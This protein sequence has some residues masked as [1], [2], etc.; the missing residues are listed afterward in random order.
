MRRFRVTGLLA[1]TV[2]IVALVLGAPAGAVAQAKVEIHY[3]TYF[4]PAG[5]DANS[6]AQAEFIRKFHE[7]NPDIKVVMDFVPWQ[8]L[9]ELLHQSVAAGKGPD[10]VGVY[11]M[12]LLQHLEAGNLIPLD[13]YARELASE[14]GDFL[15]WEGTVWQGKKW[16]FFREILVEMLFVRR[17]LVT[18]A[19]APFPPR[20][21]KQVAQASA[22]ITKE[23]MWGIMI[24]LSKKQ[25]ANR[26]MAFFTYYLWGEEGN[27]V[28][29]NGRAAFNS[30]AG[31]E[32]FEYLRDLVDKRRS[33]PKSVVSLSSEDATMAMANGTAGM[34][35]QNLQRV[36]RV[37]EG[38]G[39]GMNVVVV[40]VPSNNPSK[41]APAL[42]GGYVLGISKSS[43]HPRE[44]WRFIKHAVS[45]EAQLVRAKL[46]QSMPTRRSVYDDPFFATEQADVIRAAREFTEKGV[47]PF[48][49]PSGYQVMADALADAVQN[50]MLYN[51]PIKAELDRAAARYNAEVKK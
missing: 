27:L 40:P 43:K 25:L 26:L 49:F 33:M 11:N 12:R 22:A 47:K 50:V 3:W 39:I 10:V 32:A 24:P 4:D 51:A 36:P 19:G 28:D 7:K 8:K 35:I 46:A 45:G 42:V 30:K 37:R 34:M 21:W 2:L 6:V 41:P 15:A 14:K 9:D 16:A 20:T 38:K 18:A 23:P 1:L 13:E 29:A 17:D 31:V 44:A 5:K 48:M